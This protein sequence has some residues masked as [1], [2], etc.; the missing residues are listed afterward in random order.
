M[1]QYQHD[2][3]PDWTFK[4]QTSLK[5]DTQAEANFISPLIVTALHAKEIPLEHRVH[6]TSIGNH[7][8]VVDHKVELVFRRLNS[9]MK[10]LGVFPARPYKATFFVLKSDPGFGLLLG[11]VDSL[12][13]GVVKAAALVL[14]VKHFSKGTYCLPTR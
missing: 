8:T 2:Q 10:S 1:C 7:E 4:L 11:A 6:V 3:L 9:D 12:E 14:Q 13:F 5:I